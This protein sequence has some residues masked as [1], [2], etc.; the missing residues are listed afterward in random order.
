MWRRPRRVVAYIVAMVSAAIGLIFVSVVVLPLHRTDLTYGAIILAAAVIYIEA[1]RSIERIRERIGGVPH[2]DLNSTWTFAATV[3]VHP[4]VVA[5]VVLVVFGHRWLRVRH[6]VVHRQVFSAAVT[7]VSS[8]AGA[9]ILALYTH[10]THRAASAHAVWTTYGFAAMPRTATTFLVMAGAGVVYVA[11]NTAL[12]CV[13][14]AMTQPHPTVRSVTAGWEDYA[15]EL[16]TVGMAVLVA[17]TLVDWPAALTLVFGI[18]LVLHGKVLL[19]QWRQAARTDSKTGLL[20]DQA[21]TAA[22]TDELAR[23]ARANDTVG[24]LLIDLDNFKLVNDVHGHLFGDECLLHV[25]IAIGGEL[26]SSDHVGHL[27]QPRIPRRWARVDHGELIGRFGGEEFFI[28]LPGASAAAAR[29]VAER[30]RRRI[31]SLSIPI[32]DTY[33]TITVSIGVATRPDHG[34]DLKTLMSA[35]D[36]AMYSAKNAGR[37][38]VRV[39]AGHQA[40]HRFDRPPH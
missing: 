30:I 1:S 8:Y 4:L 12:I 28:L 21:W 16:A 6:H 38:T 35:A 33:V 18:A 29:G 11:V 17:W 26:R 34:N 2:I 23:A 37:N 36:Q 7:V 22:A 3:L 13:V 27:S 20:N 5:V 25:A 10:H 31:A 9:A 15:L 19:P 32:D 40:S 14:I 24:I 39:F